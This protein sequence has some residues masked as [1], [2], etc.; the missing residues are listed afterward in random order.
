MINTKKTSEKISENF[1]KNFNVPLSFT[2]LEIFED[3]VKSIELEDQYNEF[4]RFVDK[5]QTFEEYLDYTL[6]INRHLIR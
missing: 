2:T 5:F 1:I 3:Q 4:K 6:K